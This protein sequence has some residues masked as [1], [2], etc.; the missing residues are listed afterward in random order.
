[1]RKNRIIDRSVLAVGEALLPVERTANDAAAEA[2]RMVATMHDERARAHLGGVP[3]DFGADAI[4]LASKGADHLTIAANCF[5]GSHKV[6]ADL[7]DDL[8]YG[9]QCPIGRLQAADKAA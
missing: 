2:H 4:A 3:A 1:M 7:L 9:P 8:G 5:N 6:L